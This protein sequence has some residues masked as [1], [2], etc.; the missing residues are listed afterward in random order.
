[1]SI[2]KKKKSIKILI[3]TKLL[4]LLGCSKYQYDSDL[5][6]P[7]T[8]QSNIKWTFDCNNEGWGEYSH[9]MSFNTVQV[10]KS[11]NLDSGHLELKIPDGE[12][13]G[14]LFA[15]NSPIETQKFSYLKLSLTIEGIDQSIENYNL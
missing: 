6:N 7:T 14:W 12:S 2:L 9:K 3:V 13:Q 15:P 5:S 11:Q 1:M 4:I 8:D 10:L